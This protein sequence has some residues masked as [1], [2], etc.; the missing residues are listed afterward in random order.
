MPRSVSSLANLKN[1]QSLTLDCT[2]L[3]WKT[4]DGLSHLR[5]R[6]LDLSLS[7]SRNACPAF[8]QSIYVFVLFFLVF[9]L[10]FFSFRPNRIARALFV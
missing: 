10:I 4:L 5:L 1:L 8:V 7:R 9:R 6:A 2:F 3:E